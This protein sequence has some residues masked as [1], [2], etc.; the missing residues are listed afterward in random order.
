MAAISELQLT[1]ERLSQQAMSMR[2]MESKLREQEAMRRALHNQ[3]QELKGNIRVFC[4]VRPSSED[5]ARAIEC[6]ADT[7]LSIT[8][9]SDAHAFGFDKVLNSSSTQE[10]VF[11]EV[12]GLVQSALDGYKV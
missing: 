8:H 4:R 6:S 7:K 1:V 11:S 5:E 10:D 12:D 2:Q 3:I 9:N